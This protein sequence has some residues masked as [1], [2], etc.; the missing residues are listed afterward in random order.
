MDVIFHAAFFS[1]LVFIMQKQQKI[2]KTRLRVNLFIFSPNLSVL[3]PTTHPA[4]QQNTHPT[5]KR[6]KY[7]HEYRLFSLNTNASYCLVLVLTIKH[8]RHRLQ[9][10]V[11]SH[12]N[13][14]PKHANKN[15]I[16]KAAAPPTKT[17]ACI[18]NYT[19]PE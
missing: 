13:A 7:K 4:S 12:P 10:N 19:V 9:N 6:I 11:A 2:R 8:P 18:H 5:H 16:Q 15:T 1:A 3:V 17:K 14:N